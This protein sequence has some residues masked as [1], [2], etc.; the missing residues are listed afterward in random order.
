MAQ[1]LVKL[2]TGRGTQVGGSTL[3][4]PSSDWGCKSQVGKSLLCGTHGHVHVWMFS[5]WFSPGSGLKSCTPL[6]DGLVPL[7]QP[8]LAV[9]TWVSLRLSPRP[10][11]LQGMKPALSPS[12]ILPPSP[13]GPPCSA[14]SS[15]RLN[16]HPR[17]KSFIHG[18]L[19]LG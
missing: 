11:A 1:F 16:S 8:F 9:N 13:T 6:R 5:F 18:G 7:F 3:E 14:C 17:E 15:M 12:I 4:I 2:H 19:C 10:S